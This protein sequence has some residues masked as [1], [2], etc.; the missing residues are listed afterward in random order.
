MIA[1]ILPAKNAGDA[2][3]LYLHL[4]FEALDERC[5]DRVN[6]LPN[7]PWSQSRKNKAKDSLE[8]AGLIKIED[9]TIYLIGTWG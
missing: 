7:L 6:H 4:S 5:I 8:A 2:V 1:K 3:L 9:S